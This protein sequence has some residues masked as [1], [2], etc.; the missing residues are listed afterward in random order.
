VL[1]HCTIEYG[2]L[3]TNANIYLSDASPTISNCTI[4]NSSKYGIY[5]NNGSNPD[6]IYNTISSNN[7]YPVWV[8]PDYSNIR[9]NTCINNINQAIYRPAGTISSDTTWCNNGVPY[10][11]DGNVSVYKNGTSTVPPATLTIEPGVEVRFASSAR[12]NIGSGT[13]TSNKGAL[14]AQGT[15]NA[16]ITF[17]SGQATRTPGYWDGIYFHT[18]T[19]DNATVLEH[20]T[21]EYGGLGTNAN[22]YL[23][24]A[25][26]TIQYNIIRNSSHSGIYVYGAGSDDEGNKIL[27]NNF[28]DNKYAIY[29]TT[30]AAPI[31]EQNNFLGNQLYAIYNDSSG[32]VKAEDCWWNDLSGPNNLA[33]EN[34][35]GDVTYVPFRTSLADCVE[36]L[37]QN[38]APY[39]PAVISPANGALAAVQTNG[40]LIF[41]WRGGDPNP[42][43]VLRYDF[44]IAGTETGFGS[45]EEVNLSTAQ[46]VMNGLDN[47]TTYYWKVVARDNFEPPEETTGSVWSFTTRGPPPDIA[48][49][50]IFDNSTDTI[51]DGDNVKL[52]AT[53][54]NVG[55]GPCVETFNVDFKVGNEVIDTQQINPII[56]PDATVVLTTNWT[57]LVGTHTV[58]VVADID[59][60]NI[61]NNSNFLDPDLEVDDV[62][63]PVLDMTIPADNATVN[64][65]EQITF[66]LTDPNGGTVDDDEVIITVLV[67][68]SVEPVD[69]LTEKVGDV[70]I[71]TPSSVSDFVDDAYILRFTAI[72]NSTNA[73]QEEYTVNFTLDSKAPAGLAI[74]GGQVWSGTIFPSPYPNKSRSK[75]VTLTGTRSSEE[76]S[77]IKVNNAIVADLDIDDWSANLT[78][79]E[80]TN[81]LNVTATDY[82]DNTVQLQVDIE[83]DSLAPVIN[84]ITPSNNDYLQNAP[85][86]IAI[87]YTENG[88]GFSIDNSTYSIVDSNGDGV[89]GDWGLSGS[90]QLI[91]TPQNTD[92]MGEGAYTVDV[93]PADKFHNQ[94]QSVQYV[95]TIDSIPPS[96]PVV[97]SVTTP[98]TCRMQTIRGSKD[99]NTAIWHN[100][101]M[102]VNHTPDIAWSYNA[103]LTTVGDNVLSFTSKDRAGNESIPAV[104]VTIEYNDVAPDPVSNPEVNCSGDG[105]TLTLSWAYEES[106]PC[107][108]SHYR[109]YLEESTFNNDVSGL[110]VADNESAGTSSRTFTDLT[111]GQEYF[112]A[113][114]PVDENGNYNTSVTEVSCTPTDTTAPG[115]VSNLTFTAT[116]DSLS[117]FWDTSNA[118][119]F[120]EYRVY[121]EDD[122]SV[123]NNTTTNTYEVP[124]LDSGESYRLRVTVVDNDNNE[125]SGAII[126]GITLYEN[127]HPLTAVANNGYVTLSWNSLLPSD[128]L[129]KYRVYYST[130]DSGSVDSMML[131]QT[132]SSNTSFITG[133][134]NDT[135]YYFAVTT[136]TDAGGENKDV[137]NKTASA[138]TARPIP[139]LVGP[140]ISKVTVAGSD[141]TEN[142]IVTVDSSPLIIVS[143]SDTS[144]VSR[145]EFYLDGQLYKS[146]NSP[147]YACTIDILPLDDPED[148]YDLLIKA[149]DTL[150]KVSSWSFTL[151]VEIAAPSKPIITS[152]ESESTLSNANQ[153][154][155]GNAERYSEVMLYVNN[156]PSELWVS[157]GSSGKF[158]L[159]ATLVED[160]ETNVNTLKV[161][162]KNRSNNTT[163]SNPVTV[164]LDTTMPGAPQH[165]SATSKED[166]YVHLSWSKPTVGS[167]KGYNI[168]RS[169]TPDDEQPEKLN[170]TF[171][172]GTSYEDLPEADGEYYYKVS[173][174]NFSID[175]VEGPPSD[176]VPANSDRLDP[177][178]VITYFSFDGDEYYENDPVPPGLVT[179]VVKTPNDT[180]QAVPFLTITPLNGT[181]ILVDLQADGDDY[182]GT[183]VINESTP[184]GF[185]NVIFSGR[186]LA[187]NRGTERSPETLNI[188]TDGPS[189]IR[190]EIDHVDPIKNDV[191]NEAATITVVLGLDGEAG[192]APV[193]KYVLSGH[194]TP[195]LVDNLLSVTKQDGEA[196]AWDA[197]FTLP[198]DAGQAE[199]ETLKF[200]Y[201]GVDSLGN[202]S[203]QI[204]DENLFQVYQGELPPLDPPCC[205]E[206]ESLSE[207]RISL[208]WGEVEEAAGYQLYRKAPA[209]SELTEYLQ[210]IGTDNSTYI[211]EP[212]LD[213]TYTYAVAS[214]RRE[215]NQEVLSGTGTPIELV[216]D[217][218][219]PNPP[220]NLASELVPQGIKLDWEEGGQSEAVT[221]SIYRYDDVIGQTALINDIEPTE[222]IDPNPS[223]TDHNYAVTA[224]D[225]VGNESFPSNSTYVDWQLL[226]VSD[227]KIVLQE[228]TLPIVTWAHSAVNIQGFNIYAGSADNWTKINNDLLTD[229]NYVDIG[230]AGDERQFCVYAVNDD[231]ETSLGHCI[232]LPA[233]SAELVEGSILKRRLMNSLTYTVTN[234]SE[235]RVEDITLKLSLM[236]EEKNQQDE[237]V[238]V[239]KVH[240]SEV[241]SIDADESKDVSVIVGGYEGL[242][243]SEVITATIELTPNAG[244]KVEIISQQTVTVGEGMLALGILNSELMR[245]TSGM[246]S[247]TLENTGDEQI[248][249]ITATNGGKSDSSEINFLLTDE[250]GNVVSYVP[251]K[252]STGSMLMTLSNGVTVA[253]IPAGAIFESDQVPL[254]VPLSAPLSARIKVVIDA[255]HSGINTANGVEMEGLSS[256]L[257]LN[258][259]ETTYYGEIL[260]IDPDNS[261]GDDPIKIYGQAIKR[262]DDSPMFYVP[263]DLVISTKGFEREYSVVTDDQGLFQYSF[264]PLEN[265]AGTYK[266]YAVHPDLNDRANPVEFVISRVSVNP[267]TVTLKIPRNYEYT[268]SITVQAADGTVVENLRLYYE[269]ADL[270][271]GLTL[272]LDDPIDEL[273]SGERG[274]LSINISANNDVGDNETIVLTLKSGL[275]P[276]DEMEWGTV[277]I[278]AEFSEA[279]PI[280]NV[281]PVK[282][283]TGV[284]LDNTIT[285]LI[286]LKN[287]GLSELK[288]VNVSIVGVPDWITLNLP[289]DMNS[290]PVG[291]QRAVGI[292]INPPADVVIDDYAF[293]I[294]I[295]SSNHDNAT[296][297]LE[298]AVVEEG[299]GHVEFMIADIYTGTKRSDGTDILGVSNASIYVQNEQ[300][301]SEER[302]E[303]TEANGEFLFEGLSVGKYK[304]RVRASNHQDYI[305]RFEIRAGKTISEHVFIEY[306]LVTVEWS[307]VETTI[308]DEYEIVL[309]VTY[310]TNVPAAVVVV[311]P[312]H[313]NLP[314]MDPGDVLNLELR[315]TNYGLLPAAV[316][317]YNLPA[318]NSYYKFEILCDLPDEIPAGESFSIPYRITCLSLLDGDDGTGG[319]CS[320]YGG[321]SSMNYSSK[322]ENDYTSNGKASSG[323]SRRSSG[324]SSDGGGEGS[325]WYG[326]GG[327]DM[328]WYGGFHGSGSSSGT[329]SSS[330]PLNDECGADN[331]DD[332]NETD[333]DDGDCDDPEGC[334]EEDDQCCG[335]GDEGQQKT[336]SSVDLR[337][338]GYEDEVLD[339]SVKVQG[340]D[341]EIKRYYYNNSWHFSHELKSLKI[342]YGADG[343]SIESI[344][345][346]DVTYSKVDEQGTVFSFGKKKQILKKVDGFL[347]QN[348]TSGDWIEYDMDGRMTS[349][350]NAYD[351]KVSLLYEEEN[352]E[353]L[354]R[355]TDN[356]GNT[357]V[358]FS[359]DDVNNKVSVTDYTNR[360][361]IY[362][363][364]PTDQKLKKVTDLLGNETTYYY[365]NNRLT[366]KK[367]PDNSSTHIDYK[368]NGYVN[369]VT[370]DNGAGHFFNYSYDP[371]KQEYYSKV[372]TSKG[373]VEEKWFDKDK[374]HMRTDVNGRTIKT[375]KY[376]GRFKEVVGLGGAKEIREYDDLDNLIRIVYPDESEISYTYETKAKYSRIETKTNELGVV[377]RYVYNENGKVTHMYEAEGTDVER[378]TEYEYFDNGLLKL[379]R[380]VG[381]SNTQTADAETH[382]TYDQYGNVLTITDPEQN[383]TEFRE[384]DA[385]GNAHRMI[386]ARNKTVLYDYD[387]MGNLKSMTDQN[388]KITHFEYDKRGNLITLTAPNN[389]I[390]RYTYDDDKNMTS[391][392]IV[393]DTE[394]DNATTSYIYDT[395]GNM[396]QYVDA[397]GNSR[398]K[399]YDSE[400]RRLLSIDGLGNEM[401]YEYDD[402]VDDSGSC[403][404]CSPG[405]T[406]TK[407]SRVIY[408]NSTYTEEFTYDL[409]GRTSKRILIPDNDTV[410]YT[411]S[412]DYDLAGHLVM[413]TDPEQNVTKYEY[414]ELGR[415]VEHIKYIDSLE[416]ITRFD[417][418]NRG[419]IV[420]VTDA[421]NNTTVFEYDRNNRVVLERRPMG[422]EI[423][424]D[425]Y[426]GVGNLKKII[427]PEGNFVEYDYDNASRLSESRFYSLD[428]GSVMLENTI[429]SDFN[430]IG[431]LRY[432]T[433]GT[434]SNTIEYD[435]KYRKDNE[436]VD[437][438]SFSKTYSYTYYANGLKKSFIMPDGTEYE[439]KYGSNNELTSIL[440]EDNSTI[441]FS[442]YKWNRPTVITYPGGIQRQ[443]GYDGLMRFSSINGVMDYE[444]SY[445]GV[446]NIKEKTTGDGDY[447]YRYDDLYRLVNV[448]NPTP[449]NETFSY[450]PVGDRLR[451]AGMTEDAD[452]NENNE[453]EQYGDTSFEYDDNGNM[454]SKI[455][456]GVVFQYNYNADNRLVSIFNENENE[457]VASYGYDAVGRRVWKDVGGTK[458]YFLYADEGLVAEY[459]DDGIEIRSYLFKPDSAWG[460]DPVLQRTDEDSGGSSEMYFYHNDHLG[461]P[462]VLVDMYGI[463][464]WSATYNSFGEALVDV[465]TIE[466][467]LRFPGQYYD[468]ES[469]LH[470]NWFRYYDPYTGRYISADP[471][472][473]NGGINL[474]A[475]VLNDPVN[476]I[477]PEGLEQKQKKVYGYGTG[478]GR[479]VKDLLITVVEAIAEYPLPKPLEKL[480]N[481]VADALDESSEI[482]IEN[483][484]ALHTKT[485][486]ALAEIFED[487]ELE[488][489]LKEMNEVEDGTLLEAFEELKEELEKLKELTQK[490]IEE[491]C[492]IEF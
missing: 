423:L 194:E 152:P 354:T 361:V 336:N 218:T 356:H 414:D 170:S 262:D 334:C 381:D 442:D 66:M 453:L 71:F 468:E 319:G 198:D 50:D 67:E 41:S 81:E 225:A 119:D 106:T 96:G 452:Y 331:G 409:R 291:E 36:I 310:E 399:E 22:I 418:D 139:D 459:D 440:F 187:G 314:V 427:E 126:N 293:N 297:P 367:Y 317:S 467:N 35:Y 287:D 388:G 358:T 27:C 59:D 28:K 380:R 174:I 407:P 294:K 264:E 273:G 120:K 416:Q 147:L 181:P 52:T 157:V 267:R 307:V 209:E 115:E 389:G 2:G 185:A 404:S 352:P 270:P 348:R 492:P 303:K 206:G 116:T 311:E 227:L 61:A 47:G 136:V 242:E 201:R 448:D 49:V 249:I 155:I 240:S 228:D 265:E 268:N 382:F 441:T 205:L 377:T 134:T 426:D 10:Y 100:E 396:T 318:E 473:L 112:A 193:L 231:N 25:N 58:K 298:V 429:T 38:D 178:A 103:E 189:V 20:C 142:T 86:T 312:T 7:S 351:V 144:G 490:K 76:A 21:I 191:N 480:V 424:Y 339:M 85:G 462:Q 145:V 91:F 93:T 140:V 292:V 241:F 256:S 60:G 295:T 408:P 219:P 398:Y 172:S 346:S 195:I 87:S 347:W 322:C 360:Q 362:T 12:L 125:S 153:N 30:S 436:T 127:P 368:S 97:N 335:Q 143:A 460:T 188:D 29:T 150:G 88:S 403:S 266:V 77:E 239:T 283:V 349:Y 289:S 395:D 488:E 313:T 353:L 433:D 428:D 180:L 19:D 393:G 204:N 1:E 274:E 65:L 175:P 18:G 400:G 487:E 450:D 281:S 447:N 43:D 69:G 430:D 300:V 284:A 113:V 338:G 410:E 469:K 324:C 40:E 363:Y 148:T 337:F 247:F 278:F 137:T 383:V 146:D 229:M 320:S 14:K 78:L 302:T 422:E 476:F 130:V 444:Y 330:T 272:V 94:G 108:F 355:M 124:D 95:F 479:Q 471:I 478:K 260:S 458:T 4:T 154:V 475:Y 365:N 384:Y 121:F 192:S 445:D 474:Y 63:W 263:L 328:G 261:T 117:F 149:Y 421:D 258:L 105:G 230:Y 6:I 333:E 306:N 425:E 224:V 387:D 288:D 323:F 179:V 129:D 464:V 223:L 162:S 166:G 277:T 222:V 11:V 316:D 98:T 244:E 167:I 107:D 406:V 304:Y 183:F 31:I 118:S 483:Y 245:G 48:V 151:K 412:Y 437:F 182:T 255:I 290:V 485:L 275:T 123:D 431:Q 455:L 54:T 70:F 375:V 217:A 8:R 405:R 132:T 186:D 252:Q 102:I 200:E 104:E 158:S 378:V 135:D 236:V 477:D 345:K 79:S 325:V 74:T 80:G 110:T 237:E 156:V 271:E 26:P 296:F 401:N 432:F 491:I 435:D 451:D 434:V 226:P 282:V 199:P 439:Y 165:L 37:P 196:Q 386:D 248:E 82:A 376:D 23:S 122:S 415:K 350:G 216:S 24:D 420:S 13:N 210:L 342:H 44:Y 161:N 466:N 177:S 391:K 372:T 454:I 484:Y 470:Y 42:Y 371:I 305:G 232:T 73:N 340:H 45:A 251:F 3:G 357:V 99:N 163:M 373:K 402:D 34:I 207:G 457:T 321:S 57:A 138:F 486:S 9:N 84:S 215:N 220:V 64:S 173:A 141:A 114:A 411:T 364:N 257:E 234:S 83:V 276:E 46:Y 62:H 472:G 299:V 72:D 211:D 326:G 197:S 160:G 341:I 56:Y 259:V 190:L 438:G 308:V 465:E 250:D 128:Y 301:L 413:V 463:V 419:N 359:Y 327:G 286:F 171:Y 449:D 233:V 212:A 343:F 253:R 329:F 213:G 392:T 482:G 90:S 131:F 344:V 238:T 184:V 202:V 17:T 89:T 16:V 221:W 235:A 133:L 456:D 5:V 246:V 489:K 461:T 111:K 53:L 394:T 280:L 33:G 443:V 39:E 109:V 315:Y 101:Q 385:A 32:V 374:R 446:S 332:D 203:T 159:P 397:V 379:V 269:E 176:E 164:T 366:R 285:E 168:Y 68:N 390:V 370:D 369:S 214:I 75:Q 279:Q 208:S 417:Y 309:D 92:D 169:E 15:Q 481:K 254:S 243:D 51:N 55:N